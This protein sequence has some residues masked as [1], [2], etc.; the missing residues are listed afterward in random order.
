MLKK[1]INCSQI[2]NKLIGKE[3]ES[4]TTEEKEEVFEHIEN[5]SECYELYSML[6]NFRA[7]LEERH[8][9]KPAQ[10][11]QKTLVKYLQSKHQTKSHFIER[12]IEAIIAFLNIKIPVYQIGIGIFIVTIG[13]SVVKN[14][15]STG[16][17]MNYFPESKFS[18]QNSDIYNIDILEQIEIIEK[19]NI[20]RTAK[21]DSLLN[22]FIVQYNEQ[23]II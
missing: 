19:R 13:L 12:V 15:N 3:W 8:S 4:L 14:F 23:E 20:G 17:D 6:L 16:I 10:E 22:K 1:K 9:I 21:E 5:C 11:I 18:E 7:V 2:K